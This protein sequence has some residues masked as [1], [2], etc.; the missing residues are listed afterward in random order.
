MKVGIFQPEAGA[1]P[2]E[3]RLAQIAAQLALWPLDLLI[4]PELFLSG[5][6]P[7]AAQRAEPRDGPFG[8]AVA[9]LAMQ[10]E[11]A[12][13]YGYPEAAQAQVY[14]AA[15]LYDGTGR[16]IATHRKRLPSPGSFEEQA[17][18]PGDGVTFADLLGWRVAIIICYE[19]EFPEI[20]RHAAFEGAE[21]VIVPTALG[22][23]W[24]VVAEHVVPARAY[25]NGLFIAYAD[26]VGEAEG[27]SFFGGSRVVGPDGKPYAVANREA[28]LIK[29]TLKKD[30]LRRMRA[31]IPF[32]RDCAAL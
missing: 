20:L 7:D 23:D 32:L 2:A 6:V 15:A 19:V 28:G 25:E 5:Y 26:Q 22:A 18:A 17:F 12:I 13:A 8:R 31:R 10:S 3:T 24:G 21:L 27:L 9:E 29:A 14:N 11:T 30:E 4:C 16:L 1:L